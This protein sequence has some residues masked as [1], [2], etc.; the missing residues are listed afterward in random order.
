MRD[1]D[2][3]FQKPVILGVAD[4]DEMAEGL[5]YAREIGIFTT[6]NYK[7][8][9]TLDNLEVL[10]ELTNNNSLRELIEA[11]KPPGVT[12]IDHI[13]VR[14]LWNS[15]QIEKEKQECLNEIKQADLSAEKIETLFD[16]FANR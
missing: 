15:L 12:L 3:R 7:K 1:D 9:Y 13:A 6:D 4:D 5:L 11:T 10:I 14:S 16:R 2:F 8:L